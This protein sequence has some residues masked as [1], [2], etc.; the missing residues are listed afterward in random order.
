MDT[1]ATSARAVRA[2]KT[3][4]SAALVALL[5]LA[6]AGMA[7][8]ACAPGAGSRAASAGSGLRGVVASVN[9][10]AFSFT[11]TEPGGGLAAR[12]NVSPRTEFRGGLRALADL[13]AGMTVTV[14][15]AVSA[16]D[17][18]V[19][20]TEVEDQPDHDAN[21]DNGANDGNGARF[22][23]TVSAVNVAG[24]SFG[25][26]LASGDRKTVTV[27]AGTEFEGGLRGIGSLTAGR[28]VSV[29]G[30]L[31]ADGSV[32]AESVEAENEPV[33][34][35]GGEISV[36]G[37]IT[38]LDA[39]HSSFLLTVATGGS[40]TVVTNA[41]TEF[42]GGFSGFSDLTTGMRV[43]VE[44]A[45]RSDGSVLA[46][47]VHREDSGDSSSGS[48]SSSGDNGGGDGGHDGSD[49]SGRGSSGGSGQ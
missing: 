1:I 29:R 3:R 37:V 42:D 39:S 12:V 31:Q 23:G 47:R 19:D 11:L 21:D 35:Q 48:G 5:L 4:A 13:K 20:A 22:E 36:I 16:R 46:T 33:E 2:V 41:R 7:L 32:A 9:L 49:V 43:E 27:T 45:P 15:G 24:G 30:A 17:G 40:G 18:A 28:R 26:T 34:G 10:N 38:A 25:L 6:G 14:H 44:G 8:A